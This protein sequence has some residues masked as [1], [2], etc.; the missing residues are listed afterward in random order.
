M[1]FKVAFFSLIDMSKR[2]TLI[3]AS[4]GNNLPIPDTDKLTR[5]SM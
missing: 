4:C 1:I 5:Y 3:S 2:F